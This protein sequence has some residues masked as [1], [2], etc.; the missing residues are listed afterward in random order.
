MQTLKQSF[1]E[2]FNDSDHSVNN[3]IDSKINKLNENVTK[4]LDEL[5]A[6]ISALHTELTV[7]DATITRVQQ[8]NQ[9]LKG[10]MANLSARKE[11][12]LQ[13]SKGIT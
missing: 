3:A 7:Q 10:L 6:T 5:R 2:I 4:K 11:N 12:I 9:Q 1:A 8:E 13:E